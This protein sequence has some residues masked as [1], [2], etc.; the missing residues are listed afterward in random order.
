MKNMVDFRPILTEMESG[1]MSPKNH[2]KPNA[3]VFLP[4]L[5]QFDLDI[6]GQIMNKHWRRGLNFFSNIIR[7]K[8]TV[9]ITGLWMRMDLFLMIIR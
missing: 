3:A 7:T 8:S 5:T 9:A 2:F 6:P 1:P 4:F